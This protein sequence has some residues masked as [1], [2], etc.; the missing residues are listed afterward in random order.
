[1]HCAIGYALIAALATPEN[2]LW[3]TA[4]SLVLV[5]VIAYLIHLLV[6]RIPARM[7]RTLFG[8]VIERPVRALERGSGRIFGLRPVGEKLDEGAPETS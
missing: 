6:E 5:L 3:V 1:V 4:G 8:L 2:A 7:W